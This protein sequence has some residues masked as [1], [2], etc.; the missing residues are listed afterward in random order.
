MPISIE[1][2]DILLQGF[3]DEGILL[4]KKETEKYVKEIIMESDRIE[5]TIRGSQ[6]N[7]SEISRIVVETAI[8]SQNNL[9]KKK[10]RSKLKICA[11]L[12]SMILLFVAGIIFNVD[13]FQINVWLMGCFILVSI[14]GLTCGIVSIMIGDE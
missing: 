4:L 9:F 8:S 5:A 3:T 6:N 12:A 7:S 14:V 10:K 1:I 11:Q 2:N 13:E